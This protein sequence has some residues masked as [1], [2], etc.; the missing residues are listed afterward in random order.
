MDSLESS[1]DRTSLPKKGF[2]EL[3]HGCLNYNLKVADSLV[4]VMPGIYTGVKKANLDKNCLFN[5]VVSQG[6]RDFHLQRGNQSLGNGFA[7]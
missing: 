1:C 2:E 5:V 4:I 7:P 3:Y 6:V